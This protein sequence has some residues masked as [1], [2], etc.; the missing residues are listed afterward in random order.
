[1]LDYLRQSPSACYAVTDAARDDAILKFV[2][3]NRDIAH[4]LYRRDAKLRLAN[5]APY[6]FRIDPGEIALFIVLPLKPYY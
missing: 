4:G 2:Q 6:L 1:M 5:Y 3:Q